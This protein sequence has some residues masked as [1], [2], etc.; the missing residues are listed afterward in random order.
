MLD[1]V[2]TLAFDT[3][4]RVPALATPETTGGIRSLRPDEPGGTGGNVAIALARLGA[5]PRLHAAVG[6]DFAASPYAKRLREAGVILDGLQESDDVTARA[7]VFHDPQGNQV[8]YFYSGAS[9]TFAARPE[10]LAGRRVHFCAGEISVYPALMEAAE[11]V[12]FDPGQEIFHRELAEVEACLPLVDLLFV[13]RHELDVLATRSSWTLKRML[14]S[15]IQLV[16]ESRGPEGTL[17]HS[18][19]GRFAAPAAPA[20][21]ADPTGAGDAHRA[22]FLFALDRG[23]DLG[24]AARFANVLGAAAVDA[25]GAQAGHLT[26]GEALG[27]YEKTYAERPF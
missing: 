13:N 1:I 3:L 27:R 20:T 7:Y 12:S 11:W 26:L 2:G 25:V 15:G 10:S 16:V 17:V 14:E 6:R 22:G 8:T 21:V 24:R 19:T 18:P 5:T 23:A 4:A 9:R